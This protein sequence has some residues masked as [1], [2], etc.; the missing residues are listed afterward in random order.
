[1]SQNSE[2]SK[3]VHQ[4]TSHKLVYIKKYAIFWCKII[5]L[6]ISFVYI[7]PIYKQIVNYKNTK[8]IL[9]IF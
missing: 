3:T 2:N 1:M 7:K 6:N 8:S 9:D 4:N 5:Y